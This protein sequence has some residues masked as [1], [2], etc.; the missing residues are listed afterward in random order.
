MEFK[1]C[2]C[3]CQ[4]ITLP[5]DDKGVPLKGL[6]ISKEWVKVNILDLKCKQ[7]EKINKQK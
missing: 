3:G 4:S 2:S 5:P 1:P 6:K 7:E